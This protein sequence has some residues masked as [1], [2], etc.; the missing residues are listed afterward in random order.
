[1]WTLPMRTW[2]AR[3]PPPGR[4]SMMAAGRTCRPASASASST[5]SR[6]CIEAHAAE[7]AEL[8]A[9]DNGKPRGHGDRDRHSRRRR[10][11]SLHGR[12]G[13]EA[14]RRADRADRMPRGTVFSYV[15]REP[16]GV[17]AQIVPWNFPLLMADAE[18][19]P[20]ARG[21]LHAGPEARRADLAHRAAPRRFRRRSGF[22]AGR[23]QRHHR[24]WPHR[25][26]SLW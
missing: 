13:I 4:P 21:R 25:R 3:S 23:H 2:T 11:A 6:I 24:Q 22:P 7:F 14:R 19:R 20:G 16:I 17:A 10:S 12:L 1:M 15:S 18:D 8:E 26:R 5:S 9:I